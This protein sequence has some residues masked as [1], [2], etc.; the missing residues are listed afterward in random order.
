[1]LVLLVLLLLLPRITS[2]LHNRPNCGSNLPT[3]DTV[4]ERRLLLLSLPLS[5]PLPL[6][7]PLLL[8][9]FTTT[10]ELLPSRTSLLKKPSLL[11]LLSLLVLL[12]LSLSSLL[13]RLLRPSSI[14]QKQRIPS[15]LTDT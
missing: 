2:T 5:L 13:L 6:P 12:S 14:F 9:L 7:L 15:S 10:A 8:S 3:H 4:N 1:M 11:L